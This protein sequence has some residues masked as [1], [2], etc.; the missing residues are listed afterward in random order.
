MASSIPAALTS[1]I[2]IL[3]A[4]LPA[5][6]QVNVGPELP[7][8]VAPQ[9]LEILGVTGDQEWAELGG[10]Y[11]REETYAIHCKLTAW[12]GDAD[13]ESRFQEALVLF[14]TVS[15]A[16]GTNPTLNSTVRLSEVGS[17]DLV[18]ILTERGSAA[19]FAFQ[20]HASQRI[21]SLS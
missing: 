19:G 7:R 1:L 15:V 5:T 2:Q 10:N 14:D 18:P 9:T 8:Y 21:Q 6:T 20:V 12:A 13:W 17:L 3:T 16:V 4:A 11:K